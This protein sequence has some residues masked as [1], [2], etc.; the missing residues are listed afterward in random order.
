MFVV[1]AGPT[2]PLS[3]NLFIVSL[4]LE[5]PISRTKSKIQ[6]NHRGSSMG[7]KWKLDRTQ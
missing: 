2:S 7:I 3:T 5:A 1:S 4:N 6:R